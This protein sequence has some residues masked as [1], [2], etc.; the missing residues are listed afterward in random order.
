MRIVGINAVSYGS[1]GTI[2]RN[3]ADVARK[4][5]IEYYTFSKR[6]NGDNPNYDF[7]Y[8]ISNVN[9]VKLSSRLSSY[10]G[11]EG[12]WNYTETHQLIKQLKK[13]NPDII[14]LHNLHGWYLNLPM[15]FKFIKNNNIQVVW[16]FHDC[17]PF[18]AKCPHFE[19]AN[20]YK[21][22]TGCKN[23]PQ[24]NLY[25][26]QKTDRTKLMFKLKK[27]WFGG[28]KSMTIVT[29]SYWLSELVKMSY[30]KE[31]DIKV[32]NNGI[33]L[34][35]FKP[36]NSDFRDR[37]DL[38]DFKI[39]LGVASDWGVRKGLDVF[40]ELA[41]ILP[42]NYKIVLVGVENQAEIS[43]KIIKISSVNANKLAQIYS[44]A[45]VFV[46]PTR[47]DNYPTVN[48]EAL[49]C[50]TPVVT[51]KTGGSPEIV[52]YTDGGAVVDKDDVNALAKAIVDVADNN[53]DH[54]DGFLEY[55][56]KQSKF[57]EYCSL[58]K[59]LYEESNGC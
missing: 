42:N 8:Y 16:T 11:I 51:F 50:G 36:T 46:N 5:G 17:W 2:M 1:T 56:D 52:E 24:L 43:R 31:Y 48:V 55:F 3:I 19:L 32:I 4:K 34:E 6:V 39:A 58:Y 54:F 7:H 44:A 28:V 33:D 18:T 47:E 9:S 25:P 37:Y 21:W 27:S 12:I 57:E 15:L 35:K 59:E 14:H 29:P 40:N 10:T 13:I 22:K 38:N 45:D 30:M 41:D 49:A 26:Q 20:C 23:C 53:K